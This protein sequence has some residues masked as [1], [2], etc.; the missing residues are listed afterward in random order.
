MDKKMK[1]EMGWDGQRGWWE[2]SEYNMEKENKVG[3]EIRKFISSHVRSSSSK[4]K[5]LS[6]LLLMLFE[7]SAH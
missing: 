1:Q 2:G 3:R 4:Q 6:S 7:L 5:A